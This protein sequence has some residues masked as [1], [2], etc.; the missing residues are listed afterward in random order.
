MADV[1]TIP[2]APPQ[3]V[4]ED[5]VDWMG[6]SGV[7]L[8]EAIKQKNTE[9]K[10]LEKRL[11]EEKHKSSGAEKE[12][13][14]LKEKLNV[15]DK[16]LESCKAVCE[17]NTQ[18]KMEVEESRSRYNKVKKECAY[19]E[20]LVAMQEKRLNEMR[21]DFR[22]LE[23]HF[24]RVSDAYERVQK[25]LHRFEQK[26]AEQ[27]GQ[28]EEKIREEVALRIR[29]KEEERSKLRQGQLKTPFSF[30]VTGT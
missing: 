30:K 11:S 2:S 14:S 7:W 15:K 13:L 19:Y 29:I 1:N 10:S 26:E 21:G 16:A 22:S 17:D 18:I 27:R 24:K 8:N 3:E 5:A 20:K 28:R 23:R 9:I 4:F 25:K 12:C 6:C